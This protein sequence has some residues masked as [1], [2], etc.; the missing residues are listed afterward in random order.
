M[1]HFP[2]SSAISW[3]FLQEELDFCRAKLGAG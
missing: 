3:E 1:Q 2:L